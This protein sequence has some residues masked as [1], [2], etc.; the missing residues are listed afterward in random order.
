[1]RRTQGIPVSS[2]SGAC[3]YAPFFTVRRA[4]P[5]LSPAPRSAKK[6]GRRLLPRNC[7]RPASHRAPF[8]REGRL[9]DRSPLARVIG[10]GPRAALEE[11]VRLGRRKRAAPG[12]D[13]RGKRRLR[14]FVSDAEYSISRLANIEGIQSSV[15]HVPVCLSHY[16]AVHVLAESHFIP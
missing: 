13:R 1:M 16:T 15:S 11:A 4:W 14:E 6:K 10:T 7:S 3:S 12:R 5:W 8:F 9:K 2:V